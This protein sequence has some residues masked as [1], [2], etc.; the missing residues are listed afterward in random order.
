VGTFSVVVPEATTNAAKDPSFELGTLA[1]CWTVAVGGGTGSA[2]LV[3]TQAFRGTHS[4]LMT[5]GTA[6]AI[7]YQSITAI[8][9]SYTLSCYVLRSGG[10]AITAADCQAYIDGAAVDWDS[11]T[12]VGRYYLC[13][14]T[15]VETAAPHNTGVVAKVGGAAFYVD[16]VQFEPGNYNTTFVDGD[17]EGCVW[18]GPPYVSQ[19]YC[20]ANVRS[21][22]RVVDIDDTYGTH[23]TMLAGWGLSPVTHNAGES[24]SVPG[25]LFQSVKTGP[26]EITLTIDVIEDARADYHA[27]RLGLLNALKPD[28]VTP[29]QPVMLRYNRG[30]TPVEI[31]VVYAGGLEGQVGP[32]S[33]ETMVV[34]LIAYDPYW[35]GIGSDFAFLATTSN[36]TADNRIIQRRD[37]VWG[38]L[39]TG[40]DATAYALAAPSTYRAAHRVRSWG[41]F[42]EGDFRWVIAS[43]QNPTTT[44]YLGGAF[45]TAG[46]VTVNGIAMWNNSAFSALGTGCD[47]I[48]GVLCL[49]VAPNGTLY[50]GGSFPTMSGVANTV[51]IAKWDGANWTPL[52]TG[53]TGGT[54]GVVAL[55]MDRNGNLYAGGD[56]TSAGGITGTSR[57][58]RWGTDSAWHSIGTSPD[59]E[60][61]ALATTI[62]ATGQVVL[63]VGGTF[64]NILGVA[65]AHLA[66]LTLDSSYVASMAAYAST[67]DDNVWAIKVTSSG[68]V[69]VGGEFTHLGY[70]N[71]TAAARIAYLQGNAWYALGAGCNAVVRALAE[72]NGAIIAGGLFTQAGGVE[73]ADALAVWNGKQWYHPWVDLAGSPATV[74]ALLA[75]GNVLTVAH[76]SAGTAVT[77]GSTT[78]T[79]L[80]T[81]RTYPTIKIKRVG[82]TSATLAF[83]QNVTTGAAFWFDYALLDGETLTITTQPGA[84]SIVSDY[85]GNVMGPSHI[86]SGA[87]SNWYLNPGANT[88]AMWASVVGGPTVTAWLE[89]TPLY[90][91][92]DAA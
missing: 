47:T 70:L 18:L 59:N 92:V 37:G 49:L 19:S 14:K 12:Y 24:A 80:G 54:D 58:A 88:I 25:G 69:Y 82:G 17:Q 31:A 27:V 38:A 1:T 72:S 71:V 3:I 81:Q 51:C 83:V 73:F 91:T 75:Q 23:T 55:A 76:N 74:N 48:N 34:K 20:Y 35:H 42:P 53:C 43:E 87:F 39:S 79:N 45:A 7:L 77:T 63:W 41:D 30:V 57:L 26:R 46:G 5:P 85:R 8:A 64:H 56:F 65:H 62:D 44:L 67:A 21:H 78:V 11:I 50:A 90:D 29:Q 89:Y 22:G 9:A 84:R 32:F 10:G 2:A 52:G 4:V 61:Y 40:V 16:C 6:G 15:A 68:Q 86:P 13:V 28:L 66:K 36:I 60:V 33:Y